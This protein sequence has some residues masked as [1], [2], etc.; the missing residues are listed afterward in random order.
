MRSPTW[1]SSVFTWPSATHQPNKSIEGAVFGSMC[2]A[3]LASLLGVWLTGF[4]WWLCLLAAYGL[5]V[6]GIAGDL[7]ES[8]F[9]R[10]HGIKD[11]GTMLAGHGGVLDRIDSLLIGVLFYRPLLATGLNKACCKDSF[12]LI[13]HYLLFLSSWLRNTQSN[14]GLGTLF[15]A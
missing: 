1:S 11:T 14:N 5:A 6:S 10:Q 15:K 4:E 9:K 7:L 13:F 8:A 2:A 3:L 12:L